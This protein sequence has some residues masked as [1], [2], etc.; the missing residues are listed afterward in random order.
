MAPIVNCTALGLVPDAAFGLV[1]DAAFGFVPAAPGLCVDWSVTS[2]SA[3]MS[4]SRSSALATAACETAEPVTTKL[5]GAEAEPLVED[6]KLDAGALDVV[7][8]VEGVDEV[9]VEDVEA[10]DVLLPSLA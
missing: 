5:V 10:D 8:E 7:V 3:G 1:P 2:E 6:A 4:A 9:L